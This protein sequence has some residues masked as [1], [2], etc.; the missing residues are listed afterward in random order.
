MAWQLP[1]HH[2]YSYSSSHSSLFTSCTAFSFPAHIL[3]LI[4]SHRIGLDHES[5]LRARFHIVDRLW[6]V[7]LFNWFCDTII[8]AC[9]ALLSTLS[10]SLIWVTTTV[11]CYHVIWRRQND[12][13]HSRF[14]PIADAYAYLNCPWRWGLNN[15]QC[16]RPP[17][18]GLLWLASKL[19]NAL[20]FFNRA[21]QVAEQ[22]VGSEST[23]D[24]D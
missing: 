12:W 10:L 8:L 20:S 21:S 17:V 11:N 14:V 24:T 6:L 3:I 13:V 1:Q 22:A 2:E 7:I 19:E 23:S 16:Y 9:I 4:L 18:S 15:N 5:S